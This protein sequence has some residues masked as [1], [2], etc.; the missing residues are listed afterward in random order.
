MASLLLQV[1]KSSADWEAFKEASG[2]AKDDLEQV[3]ILI[4]LSMCT[5]THTGG[6]HDGFSVVYRTCYWC[7]ASQGVLAPLQCVTLLFFSSS[8]YS[9][10]RPRRRGTAFWPRKSFWSAATSAPSRKRKTNERRCATRNEGWF[11]GSTGRLEL[12]LLRRPCALLLGC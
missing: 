1:T 10:V 4:F 8:L 3:S 9:L 7:L 2:A 5:C 6:K 11:G 12:V